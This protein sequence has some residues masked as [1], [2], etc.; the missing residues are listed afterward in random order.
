MTLSS[1]FVYEPILLKKNMNANIIKTQIFYKIKYVLKGHWGSQK[2]FFLNKSITSLYCFQS[3]RV[4]K[5]WARWKR[6]GSWLTQNNLNIQKYPFSRFRDHK[7]PKIAILFSVGKSVQDLSKVEERR[8]LVNSK[9]VS[10][11]SQVKSFKEFPVPDAV[12]RNLM[13]YL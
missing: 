1:I 9:S 8:Q 3:V 4:C 7:I 12:Q 13:A 5:N 2:V 6:E 11:L 10:E